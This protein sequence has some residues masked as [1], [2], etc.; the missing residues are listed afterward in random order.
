MSHGKI[1]ADQASHGNG[2]E[3]ASE[4]RQAEL[5][6]ARRDERGDNYAEDESANLN[7]KHQTQQN[8]RQ[9]L[10]SPTTQRHEMHERCKK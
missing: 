8:V 6:P 4:P 7:Q 10:S 3:S 2:E 5:P 1:L 9:E